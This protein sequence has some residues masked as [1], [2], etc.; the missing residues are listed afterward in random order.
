MMI[1]AM[2][3]VTFTVIVPVVVKFLNFRGLFEG[4]VRVMQGY[5]RVRFFFSVCVYVW[6]C[7]GGGVPAYTG[8]PCF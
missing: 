3:I 6:V 8:D 5:I 7:G 1:I 2:R 4:V